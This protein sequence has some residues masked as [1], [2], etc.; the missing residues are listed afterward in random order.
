MFFFLF[1]N[2]QKYAQVNLTLRKISISRKIP[3]RILARHSKKETPWGW[4]PRAPRENLLHSE[5]L[6]GNAQ[7][8]GL[9]KFFVT[10]GLWDCA[11]SSKEVWFNTLWSDFSGTRCDQADCLSII[12]MNG[13]PISRFRCKPMRSGDLQILRQSAPY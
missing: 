4:D 11:A 8:L 13:V 9:P 5:R 2:L 12:C 10:A 1:E 3:S 7:N 6:T